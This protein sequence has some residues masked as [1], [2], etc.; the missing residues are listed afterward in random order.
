[1]L[2]EIG[3]DSYYVIININRGAVTP[4]SPTD[5]DAFNHM[6]L[7]IKLPDDVKDDSLHA[8]L[9]HPKLG[10]LLFFDPTNEF[11]PFGQIGSYLQGNY[12]LVVAGDGS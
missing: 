3:I 2:R 6:V 7:A 10:R 8:V 9:S 12:G 1:M 11:T 4:T 5:V